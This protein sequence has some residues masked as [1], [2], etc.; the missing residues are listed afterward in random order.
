MLCWYKM[1][2]NETY[3]VYFN[4]IFCAFF[5]YFYLFCLCLFFLT[6]SCYLSNKERPLPEL[7]VVC[8]KLKALRFRCNC[9]MI[10]LLTE[11]RR[12]NRSS[13]LD[14]GNRFYSLPKLPGGLCDP[15]SLLFSLFLGGVGGLCPDYSGRDFNS[16]I[17]FLFTW[18]YNPLWLYFPQP[19]SGL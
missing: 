11:R 5:R 2:H 8:E 12:R 1:S 14:R 7:Y 15:T 13:I 3:N 17:V 16:V 18:R 4:I 6:V 9:I 19:G 10:R